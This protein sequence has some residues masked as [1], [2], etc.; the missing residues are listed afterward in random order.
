[1]GE[2]GRAL[3]L[4]SQR[5]EQSIKQSQLLT[6]EQEK[7]IVGAVGETGDA[8]AKGRKLE[9]RGGPVRGT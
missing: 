3:M 9:Q 4:L 7:G 8:E 6:A 5:G 1:M 2:G